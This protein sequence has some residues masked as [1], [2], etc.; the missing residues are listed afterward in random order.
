MDLPLF[1]I[2]DIHLMLD[3]KANGTRKQE[4]LFQFL[5]HVAESKGN[6][7]I[8][9]DLFDFWFEYNDL[10]PKAYFPYLSKLAE[11]KAKGVDL[12]YMLGNHDYWVLDFITETLMTKTYYDDTVLEFNGKKIYLTHGDGLLSWDT[13]YRALKALIRNPLFI[14]S[15][16]ALHPN[17]AYWLARKISQRGRHFVHTDEYN[18]KIV[19]DLM[20][21]AN[22]KFDEGHNYVI[23][24]HYHQAR[25]VDT[26]KGKMIILGDW[27]NYF[28]YGEFDGSELK[29][30]RWEKT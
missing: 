26:E 24:G 25:E 15:F 18:Q 4:N 21:F 7:F 11:I 6:L 27:I 23:T 3:P 14:K 8:V 19:N 16:R 22:Q 1:F 2:S 10:I 5:D 20:N 13:V 17:I 29:L 30:K 12:H 9:G 28:S